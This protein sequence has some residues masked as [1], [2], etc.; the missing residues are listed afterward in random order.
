M[1]APLFPAPELLARAFYE[2]AVRHLLD[3]YCLHRGGCAAGSIASSMKAG[4]LAAKS[5]IILQNPR[6]GRAGA[7]AVWPGQV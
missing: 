7:K 6:N 2:E 5:S 1:M 3:S 4:E